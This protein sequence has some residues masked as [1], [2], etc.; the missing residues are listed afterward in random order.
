MVHS[1]ED[2]KMAITV[3]AVSIGDQVFR[4]AALN[5]RDAAGTVV[6]IM[7]GMGMQATAGTD[8]TLILADGTMRDGTR[9]QR[10]SV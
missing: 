7:K 3:I 2:E 4:C 1:Y 5:A 6:E 10:R 9:M 8:T